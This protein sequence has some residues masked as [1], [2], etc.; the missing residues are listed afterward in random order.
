MLLKQIGSYWD[1]RAEGYS[2]TIHEQLET[3]TGARF[4]RVLR[5]G[6]PGGGELNVLDV[7]CGPAFLSI[8]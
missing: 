6:A 8:L 7:G 2:L 1:T 3:E 4:R 5:E